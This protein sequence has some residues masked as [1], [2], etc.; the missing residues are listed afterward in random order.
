MQVMT[1]NAFHDTSWMSW[2]CLSPTISARPIRFD[3][4]DSSD[5]IFEI[6]A[7]DGA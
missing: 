2:D 3:R 6:M 1:H 7:L 4:V 5:P